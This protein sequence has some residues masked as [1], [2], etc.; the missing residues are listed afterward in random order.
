[1]RQTGKPTAFNS[2][3]NIGSSTMLIL[4]VALSYAVGFHRNGFPDILKKSGHL[5][6]HAQDWPL[7]RQWLLGSCSYAFHLIDVRM[8]YIGVARK[9]WNWQRGKVTN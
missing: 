8:S 1:M 3:E 6:I 9:G 5:L 4:D 7:G 2:T